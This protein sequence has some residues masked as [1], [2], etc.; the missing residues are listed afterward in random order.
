MKEARTDGLTFEGLEVEDSAF[1][2]RFCGRCSLDPGAIGEECGLLF[3][4][5]FSVEGSAF[6]NVGTGSGRG[7][8]GMMPC[9]RKSSKCMQSIPK[10]ELT[11]R[12]ERKQKSS[13]IYLQVDTVF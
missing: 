1:F 8:I 4:V 11:P 3:S 7:S 12:E 6:G 5:L 10:Q 9:A 13:R 2:L